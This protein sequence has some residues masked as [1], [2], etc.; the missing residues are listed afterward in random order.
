[1]RKLPAVLLLTILFSAAGVYAAPEAEEVKDLLEEKIDSVLEVL[2]Q[3][4]LSDREKR[5]EIEDI[6]DPVFNYEL[7]AKLALGPEHWPELSADQKKTFSERFVRRMKDSYFDKISMYSSDTDARF[8]YGKPQSSGGK[9]RVPLTAAAGDEKVEIIYKFYESS[10]GWKVYDVEADG[11]SIVK[12]YRS[13]FN[14]VL[15][16]GSIEQLLEQLETSDEFE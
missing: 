12:S 14:E 9:V 3:K 2:E 1:M 5:A 6:V 4:E 10:D 16:D 11:V 15:S 7:M 8:D 13:Q